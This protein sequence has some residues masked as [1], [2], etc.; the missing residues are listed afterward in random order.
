M[1]KVVAVHIDLGAMGKAPRQAGTLEAGMA[2]VAGAATARARVAN[3]AAMAVP[4]AKAV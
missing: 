4:A 3:L 2:A 1:A